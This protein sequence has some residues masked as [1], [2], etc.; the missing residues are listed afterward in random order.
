LLDVAP[1]RE[2]GVLNTIYESENN[3]SG[4]DYRTLIFDGFKP[5]AMESCCSIPVAE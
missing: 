5:V 1:L 2:H 4:F 3:R